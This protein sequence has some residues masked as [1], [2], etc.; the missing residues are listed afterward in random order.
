MKEN[1]DDFFVELVASVVD[2]RQQVTA[3]ETAICVLSANIMSMRTELLV[4]KGH[5]YT[6][7]RDRKV[8]GDMV[9]IFPPD[10]NTY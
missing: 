9:D 6:I 4:I 10:R 7:S 2:L 3:L 5:I 8:L 1:E